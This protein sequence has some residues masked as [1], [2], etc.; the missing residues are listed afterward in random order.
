MAPPNRTLAPNPIITRRISI[1][2]QNIF[3]VSQRGET[4]NVLPES[5]S[6]VFNQA[7]L[8]GRKKQREYKQGE[9]ESISSKISNNTLSSI[10]PQLLFGNNQTIVFAKNKLVSDSLQDENEHEYKALLV[11]SRNSSPRGNDLYVVGIPRKS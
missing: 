1:D 3:L 4:V 10:G 6:N 7:W 8:R 9:E 5:A 2:L 11:S